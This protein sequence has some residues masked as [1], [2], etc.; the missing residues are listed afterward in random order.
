M[1][2][3][4]KIALITGGGSGMGQLAARR[5][6]AAGA[7]VAAFDVNEVGLGETSRSSE[8]IY[9][10]VVDVTEQAAVEDA[11]A[12]VEADLGPVDRVYHAAAIMPLGKILDQ[13]TALIHKIM[14]INYG[15][16]V[17]MA[18]HALPP[19]LARG[20]GEF[21][22]FASLAGWFPALYVGAYNASK[23]AT[24]AFTEVL[25]HE[26]RGRGVKFVCV[27]PPPV[28][29][30]LLQQ[31]KDTVWP[32]LFDQAPPIEPGVVLDAIDASLAKGELMC[33]PT[34]EAKWG[35]RMRRWFPELMWKQVHKA[36]GF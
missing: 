13:D 18:K 25:A 2:F 12:R 7:K 34:K 15:G 19:M 21:I 27:C 36:E 17:N 33:F 26:N 23:F 24:V 35:W 20:R 22:S 32:K 10:Q 28:A 4:G 31:G 29:T 30:P 3:S 6:A 14:A 1:A 16:L 8:N 11:V 9:T 5:L